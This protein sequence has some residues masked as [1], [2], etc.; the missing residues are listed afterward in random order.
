MG[1]ITLLSRPSP[2]FQLIQDNV[3]GSEKIYLQNVGGGNSLNLLSDDSDALL[4]FDIFYD[5]HKIVYSAGDKVKIMS[6]FNGRNKISLTSGAVDKYVTV[7]PNGEYTAFERR[8]AGSGVIYRIKNDNTGSPEQLS[9]S[10]VTDSMPCYSPGG[11]T[12]AFSRQLAVRRIHTMASGGGAATQLT[13]TGGSGDY[14]PIYEPSN[15]YI[16]FTRLVSGVFQ[17]MRMTTAGGSVTQITTG[18][19]DKFCQV[20]G[21]TD[22]NTKLLYTS[23]EGGDYAIYKIA[24]DGTGKTTVNSTSG[25]QVNMFIKSV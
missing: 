16:F 8:I 19:G 3:G 25:D 14:Y 2:T 1:A 5:F 13:S 12:I 11:D 6:A 7:S 4:T 17:I 22:S 20:R 9:V 15:T 24:F 23:N 21:F 10:P 18:A